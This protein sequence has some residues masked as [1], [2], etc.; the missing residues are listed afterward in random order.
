MAD[1]TD[2]VPHTWVCTCTHHVNQRRA[3]ICNDPRRPVTES[4]VVNIITSPS[5]LGKILSPST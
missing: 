3:S 4:I 1:F 5:V 2:D